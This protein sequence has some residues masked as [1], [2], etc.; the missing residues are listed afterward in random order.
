MKSVEKIEISE[1]FARLPNSSWTEQPDVIITYR[2][3]HIIYFPQVL[4]IS[5][6]DSLLICGYYSCL[7]I[8]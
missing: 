8:R 4:L 5:D 6:D 2:R 3:R 7:H 1:I